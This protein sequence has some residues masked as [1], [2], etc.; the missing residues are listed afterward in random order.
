MF[1]AGKDKRC[2]PQLTNK[3]Q[4]LERRLVDQRAHQPAEFSLV[5]PVDGIVHWIAKKLGA[6]QMRHVGSRFYLRCGLGVN[7]LPETSA[8]PSTPR[9]KHVLRSFHHLLNFWQAIYQF[10]APGR[11]TAHVPPPVLPYCRAAFSKARVDRATP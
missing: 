11:Y 10:V 8:S 6:M 7:R 5:L 9:I 2:E 1:C 4:A 3:A